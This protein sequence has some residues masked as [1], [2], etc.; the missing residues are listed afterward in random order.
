MPTAAVTRL[1]PN[2]VLACIGPG[3]MGEV[4]SVRDTRRDRTAAINVLPADKL[5]DA[6]SACASR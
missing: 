3:G 6:G 2:E 4:Y 1:G 5:A